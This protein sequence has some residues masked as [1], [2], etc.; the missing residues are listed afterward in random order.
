M[1]W[2]ELSWMSSLCSALLAQDKKTLSFGAGSLCISDPGSPQLSPS[3]AGGLMCQDISIRLRPELGGREIKEVSAWLRWQPQ[4][5]VN[6][7]HIW[8]G[9]GDDGALRWLGVAC[10]AAYRVTALALPLTVE[11]V[12]F[13]VQGVGS[14]GAVQPLQHAV[15][16]VVLV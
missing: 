11:V 9:D 10:A 2:G 6:T 8:C 4:A 12:R 5:A 3:V 1:T 16:L 7:W 14:T 13:V 15:G